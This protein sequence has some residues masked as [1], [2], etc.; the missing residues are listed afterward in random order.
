[1]DLFIFDLDE[2]LM[3]DVDLAS[4]VP[5]HS[6]DTRGKIK[7]TRHMTRESSS[8]LKRTRHNAGRDQPT[9]PLLHLNTPAFL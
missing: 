1:V 5:R 6:S 9:P 3:S 4:T 2:V 7:H 8:K